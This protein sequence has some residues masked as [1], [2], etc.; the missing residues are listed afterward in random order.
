MGSKL[1]GGGLPVCGSWGCGLHITPWCCQ[2]LLG[3]SSHTCEILP[4]ITLALLKQIVLSL[5]ILIFKSQQLP[6][7]SRYSRVSF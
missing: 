4:I 6:A 5:L 1:R 3:R 7:D 2:S